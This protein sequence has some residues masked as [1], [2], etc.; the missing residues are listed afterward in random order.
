MTGALSPL[1][2][3]A[4][5]LATEYG[6]AIFPITPR[7][8][9]PP[10]SPHGFHDASTHPEAI[11]EW[12][13]STPDAN[14]GAVPGSI[15]CV[16]IDTDG[17]AGEELARTLS[18][19]DTA[20]CSTVTDRGAHFWFRLPRGVVIRNMARAELDV[21]SSA[22]YVVM[23]PSIHPSGAEYSWRGSL[24]DVAAAPPGLLAWLTPTPARS[25]TV[26]ARAAGTTS[27]FPFDGRRP[28]LD[29]RAAVR[30]TAYATRIGYGLSDGRKCAA[31]R[32]SAFML[33]DV[34][35][36]AGEALRFL[37]TW[38]TFNAPPLSARI[39]VDI[40]TNAHRFGRRTGAA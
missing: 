15:E 7:A 14:I 8:K 6:L 32:F 1:G 11:A 9:K 29:D 24:D 27:V 30:V 31:F 20:T 3:A 17:P 13:D 39:L 28:T 18:V 22:G 19:L 23:P 36:S 38:N 4:L 34:G 37:E 16:V 40:H 5:T 35:L 26:P 2:L 21:R 33:H 12:W 10:L 25:E